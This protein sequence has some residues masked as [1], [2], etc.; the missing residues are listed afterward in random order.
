MLRLHDVSQLI[1][2]IWIYIPTFLD[3]FGYATYFYDFQGEA[4]TLYRGENNR[5]ENLSLIE[6][7]LSRAVDNGGR[8]LAVNIN[9]HSPDKV[10]WIRS[11]LGLYLE[12]IDEF[13]GYPEFDSGNLQFMS[14]M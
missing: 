11:Q 2:A 7:A 3:W 4:L 6:D 5:G 1:L 13:E 8:V 10:E 14:I 9:S 12:D